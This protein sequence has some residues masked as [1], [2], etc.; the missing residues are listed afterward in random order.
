M[1]QARESESPRAA[2]DWLGRL[3]YLAGVILSLPTIAFVLVNAASAELGLRLADP[4]PAMF[5]RGAPL[6]DPR[7]ILG[8]PLAAAAINLAY[9]M[10]P[11]RRRLR[12]E[13]A[14]PRPPRW[15]NGLAAALGLALAAF[16]VAY[17]VFEN[18]AEA[19]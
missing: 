6:A 4:L 13:S 9:L 10:L 17:L 15:R 14:P 5:D 18:I 3:S 11:R 19:G 12:P 7:L 16:V 8:G 2:P 1:P